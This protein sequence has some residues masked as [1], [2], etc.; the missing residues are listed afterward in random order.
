MQNLFRLGIFSLFALTALVAR[1][2]TSLG[3]FGVVVDGV[4][5]PVRVSASTAEL[6]TLARIAF[7]THGRYKLV[8]SGH[9]YDIKFTA[10]APTQVRV[11]IT[12]GAAAT[13]VASAVATGTTARHALLRAADEAVVR[14][15]GLGL[16]G[17]FTARMAFV[18]QRT[19]KSEVYSSDLFLGDA[20]QLTRDGALAM[21]PRWSPDGSRIIYTSFFKTGAPDIYLLDPQTTRKDIFA[22][23]KGTNMGARFSPSGQQ[24]V[25]I[26]GETP[27]EI[28]IANAQGKNAVRKTRSDVSKSSPCWSPDSSQ[29]VFAMGEPSPQLYVMSAAGGAPRRLTT[30]Y[31]F[32]AE[33]D[34]NRVDRNKLV[35]TV[36]VGGGKFQIAVVELS[37]GKAEVVSKA[38]YDAMEPSWLADGRHV[39][40]TV[41]DRRTSALAILDTVTGSS[42]QITPNDLAAL[43]AGVWTP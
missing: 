35:C 14:T 42:L 43:Q 11:D 37:T 31:A 4:A 16:R 19:G 12:R 18:S 10:V 9:A 5:I 39:I 21:W 38:A 40:Y 28:Y 23:Y 24:V 3:E 1:A 7:S 25:M 26:A 22:N 13:P 15:N 8:A 33:P 32:S 34:W 36:R 2:A 27:G 29:I 41:R 6:D 20:K 17:F 30:G